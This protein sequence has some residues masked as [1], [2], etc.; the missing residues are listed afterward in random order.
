MSR[1]KDK[2]TEETKTNQIGGRKESRRDFVK[3]VMKMSGGE[4]ILD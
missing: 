3:E 1:E 4:K 2:L